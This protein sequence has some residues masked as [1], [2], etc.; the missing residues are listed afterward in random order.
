ML[1]KANSDLY[2]G[3]STDTDFVYNQPKTCYLSVCRMQHE[4]SNYMAFIAF[5]VP[6]K[7]V[8]QSNKKGGSFI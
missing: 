6:M 5:L 4:Q 8:L 1:F 3:H 2:D 7:E